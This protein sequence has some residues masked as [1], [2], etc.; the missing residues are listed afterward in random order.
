M[1]YLVVMLAVTDGVVAFVR[2]YERRLE[3]LSALWIAKENL[4]HD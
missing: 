4:Q 3:A 2:A 1:A